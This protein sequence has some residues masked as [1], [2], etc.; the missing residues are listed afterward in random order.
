MTDEEV[1]EA[2]FVAAS[3]HLEAAVARLEA[4]RQAWREAPKPFRNGKMIAYRN[5]KWQVLE[6]A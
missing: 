4:A 5:G 1:A 3:E 2:E 6:D